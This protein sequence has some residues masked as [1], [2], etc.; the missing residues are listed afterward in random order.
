M[1]LLTSPKTWVSVLV[2]AL[3]MVSYY[4]RDAL[5]SALVPVSLWYY[6]L[7][8]SLKTCPMIDEA[9]FR[10]KLIPVPEIKVS[11]HE[12]CLKHGQTM[13][14]PLLCSGYEVDEQYITDLI[15]SDPA[16][17]KMRC[18]DI[19]ESLTSI[20]TIGGYTFTNATLADIQNMPD[21]YAGFIIG[22]THHERLKK[23]FPNLDVEAPSANPKRDKETIK[24][25]GSLNFATS[26]LANFDK[27][28]I[29]TSDHAAPVESVV[30]QLTGE[31]VFMM[32]DHLKT[33]HSYTFSKILHPWPSCAQDYIQNIP[34]FWIAPVKPG[35]YLYFPFLW[36]HTVYTTPGTNIMTNVRITAQE[37]FFKR[38][39]D[40]IAGI[41]LTGMAGGDFRS[42]AYNQYLWDADLLFDD[43]PSTRRIEKV[44]K[45]FL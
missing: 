18:Y 13:D 11:S 45:E 20:V 36:A 16:V 27:G 9:Q 22:E 42:G 29:S 39:W 17:Y 28:I 14:H 35:S 41:I 7:P 37:Y 44:L 3:S 34:E 15:L 43:A 40:K 23:A 19:P 5:F 33:R 12:E 8:S 21:C 6:W 4:I 1:G 31:K 30:Y 24:S 26:F 32:Y 38:S 2:L 10:E 25:G